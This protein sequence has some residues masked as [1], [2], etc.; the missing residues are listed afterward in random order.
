MPLA[1]IEHAFSRRPALM[2]YFPLGYPDPES[3]LD[4][5]ESIV[6]GGAD[7]VELGLPFSDPLAD[8]PVIQYA[9]QI[10]LQHGMT[11]AR[12]L[13]MVGE[14]RRRGVAVPLLLMSYF[15]PLLA[16]GLSQIVTD[17][18]EAG[19]DGFIV[20]DL[21][22][23]EFAELDT[24]CAEHDLALIYFLAPTS[25]PER[26]ARVAQRARG[27]IYVVSLTGVTG[28]RDH[29]PAD[30]TAFVSRVRTMT[31][32]PLAV[33]FGIS[34]PEQ[35]AAIGRVADGVIIGSAL[36]KA[37]GSGDAA[38]SAGAF[39]RSLREGMDNRLSHSPG[40]GHQ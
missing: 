26:V 5:V 21:P 15:N 8:G 14:L 3:S 33:G 25:T 40:A 13:Q 16:Y 32:C 28:A 35:A 27:F 1:N 30:V 22:A 9:T 36:V 4:V 39:V 19:T 24:L 2:P 31:A 10:A 38:A 17:A 37:A 6:R 29:L 12:G 23:E 7:L 34:T 20:P 11:A 18:A